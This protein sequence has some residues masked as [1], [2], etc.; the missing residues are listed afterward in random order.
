MRRFL[1]PAPHT[2]GGDSSGD[3]GAVAGL[4]WPEAVACPS[5]N[6]DARPLGVEPELIVVHAISLPPGQFGGRFIEQLFTNA[7]DPGEHS[8]F[9]EIAGLR[10]SAHV[11]I[12]RDGVATQFVPFDQRAWH[13]GISCWNGRESC[14]DFS[15]GIELEGSDQTAFTDVQYSVLVRLIRWLRDH[16]PKLAAEGAIAGHCDIAPGR[17]TDPGPHFDWA[18]LDRQLKGDSTA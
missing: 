15:I 5:P 1:E 8:F 14:N 3:A 7:L 9:A 12:A 4:W 2:R 16:F 10:V 18:R 17:K 11:V 13:A 6:C